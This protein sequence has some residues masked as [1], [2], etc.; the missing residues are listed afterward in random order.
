MLTVEITETNCKGKQKFR[1]KWKHHP[2]FKGNV[3]Y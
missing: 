2:E 1:N 3:N